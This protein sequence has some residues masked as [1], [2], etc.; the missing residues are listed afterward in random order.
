MSDNRCKAVLSATAIR[1]RRIIFQIFIPQSD[2]FNKPAELDNAHYKRSRKTAIFHKCHN[3]RT[4]YISFCLTSVYRRQKHILML[5]VTNASHWDLQFLPIEFFSIN[6][7]RIRRFC[8]L[9]SEPATNK[10]SKSPYGTLAP[11]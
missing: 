3:K 6:F 10:R 9:F 7:W 2:S 11:R 8:E 4:R 1:K 5:W